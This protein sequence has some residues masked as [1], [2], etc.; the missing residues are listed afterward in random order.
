M[1]YHERRVYV[2]AMLR[3]ICPECGHEWPGSE[4]VCPACAPVESR[5]PK[6][7]E[8]IPAPAG[9]VR[10]I[11]GWMVSLV[12]AIVLIVGLGTLV[13]LVLGVRRT[14]NDPGKADQGNRTITGASIVVHSA[15]ISSG[16]AR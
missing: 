3:W 14:N 8:V 2:V 7:P 6:L 13:Y 15:P 5:E 9:T 11:P 16:I 1:C 4:S 12:L 10:I